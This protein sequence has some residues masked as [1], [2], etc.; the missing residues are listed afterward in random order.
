MLPLGKI[1]LLVLLV[2]YALYIVMNMML[3][4]APQGDESSSGDEEA[5]VLLDENGTPHEERL[6]M[7]LFAGHRVE[8]IEEEKE[9]LSL[10]QRIDMSWDFLL[11]IT[12][13]ILRFFSK[14]DNAIIYD[15]GEALRKNG[16]VYHH[17]IEQELEE[18]LKISYVQ[19]L[20]HQQSSNEQDIHPKRDR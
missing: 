2:L 4:S 8:L 9:K 17:D 1:F 10:E 20:Q 3:S 16:G 11:R 19:K 7:P 15:A 13:K 5:P 6:D 18:A 12:D 14:E